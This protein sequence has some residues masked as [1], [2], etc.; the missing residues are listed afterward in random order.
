MRIRVDPMQILLINKKNINPSWRG[1]E[2]SP[3]KTF[4]IEGVKNYSGRILNDV[5]KETVVRLLKLKVYYT[6]DVSS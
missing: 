3:G 1:W 6:G 5:I 4:Q 2:K